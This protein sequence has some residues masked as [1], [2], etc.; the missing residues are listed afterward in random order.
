MSHGQGQSRSS[1]LGTGAGSDAHVLRAL[2]GGGYANNHQEGQHVLRNGNGSNIP[3]DQHQFSSSFA[4]DNNNRGGGRSLSNG[5]QV[6]HHDA[7]SSSGALGQDRQGLGA[8][9]NNHVIS[10]AEVNWPKPERRPR[11]DSVGSAGSW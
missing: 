6:R 2:N 10:L 11:F 4:G 7:S 3:S 5:R 9:A 8:D 1:A